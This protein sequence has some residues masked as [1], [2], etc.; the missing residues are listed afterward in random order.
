[1]AKR[2]YPPPPGAAV[3]PGG[4]GIDGD[5]GTRRY[6]FT[7]AD[8]EH[9][10]RSSSRK[11]LLGFATALG[12]SCSAG[13]GSTPKPGGS[14][15]DNNYNGKGPTTCGGVG[16]YR[17]DPSSP[18]LGLSP[19]MASVHGSLRR[20]AETWMAD[21][22]P[23][24][25]ARAR[26]G[27]PAFRT[28]HS[29]L[30][31]RSEAI[32]RCALDCHRS[33]VL[34]PRRRRK[35]ED[36]KKA[37]D[38]GEKEK[39]SKDED[40]EMRDASADKGGVTTAGETTGKGGEGVVE[41]FPLDVLQSCSDA[42]YGAA[43]DAPPSPLSTIA[44][45]AEDAERESEIIDELRAYLHPA[46]GHPVRL[47]YGT[48]HES[49]FLIF[50][51]SL[52]KL[53]CLGNSRDKPPLPSAMAP[54]ALSVFSAYLAVTRGLQKDY[55]L[56]P[57]GS[58]GVWGLDDYHC[59]PFYFGACQLQDESREKDIT[60]RS[61]HE[62]KTLEAR[63]NDL[64]YLGCIRYVKELKPGAPFFESSPMLDDISHLPNW[65]RVA[66]GLLRLYEGEVLDKMPVVQHFEFGTLFKATWTPSQRPREAPTQTFINGPG[67]DECIAPW[68]AGSVVGRNNMDGGSEDEIVGGVPPPPTRAPWSPNSPAGGGAGG[69][70]GGMPMPSTR[71]PWAK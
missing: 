66:R 3:P 70:R 9:F 2:A 38:E 69:G 61:I 18:L 14:K 8:M 16:R 12:R 68:A 52:A 22:P 11:E 39:A 65:G 59:L 55:M 34:E 7:Q 63:G 33:R 17:Y 50:L 54:V 5:K 46:F 37:H 58:H 25:H 57:A 47:D 10:R 40:S 31:D 21:V 48:G 36:E 51:F 29:R 45:S 19:A 26:F 53:G 60:P 1:M 62:A 32:V 64:M 35:E 24:E 67:G 30:V 6:I 41:N 56:E 23:D 71:A 28:W 49:S 42:G 44:M 13:G 27:N 20:M 43:S 15:G 4:D